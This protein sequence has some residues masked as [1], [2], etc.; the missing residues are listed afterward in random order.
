VEQIWSSGGGAEIRRR[1]VSTEFGWMRGSVR[2]EKSEQGKYKRRKRQD[3]KGNR[4]N[5]IYQKR[6]GG[7]DQNMA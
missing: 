2:D 1:R 4:G 6:V 3:R 7:E 5:Q